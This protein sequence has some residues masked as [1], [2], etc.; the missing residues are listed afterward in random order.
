ML[1]LPNPC[2]SFMES[3]TPWSA[4]AGGLLIGTASAGLLLVQGRIAGIS[5]IW[6]SIFRFTPGDLLWRVFF[7][8]GLLINAIYP[9]HLS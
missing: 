7:V 4:L 9:I 2:V 6:S 3:F 1:E 8:L 5:G